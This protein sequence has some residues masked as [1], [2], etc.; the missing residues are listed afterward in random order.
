MANF[1]LKK[2]LIENK[3]TVNSKLLNESSYDSERSKLSDKIKS[4]NID[5]EDVLK[6]AAASEQL[7]GYFDFGFDPSILSLKVDHHYIYSK[8]GGKETALA[9]LNN[10][11]DRI[12]SKATEELISMGLDLG[13][14]DNTSHGKN[15][16]KLLD[17]PL[18][19]DSQ[20]WTFTLMPPDY[21]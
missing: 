14:G 10:V 4:S 7:G 6:K 17:H 13:K 18:D 8:D 16:F 20:R 21:N 2:Y 5:I 12:L 3:I 11:L 15:A 1:D 9:K 19:S